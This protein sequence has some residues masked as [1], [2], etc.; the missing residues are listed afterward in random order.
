MTD[1][2]GFGVVFPDDVRFFNAIWLVQLIENSAAG[3]NAGHSVAGCK[4]TC[5][6]RCARQAQ[7]PG[8]E[9]SSIHENLQIC[10]SSANI[11]RWTDRAVPMLK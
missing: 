7:Q 4:C 8:E 9:Q 10:Q 11:R 6:C 1:R 2:L 5:K 3:R